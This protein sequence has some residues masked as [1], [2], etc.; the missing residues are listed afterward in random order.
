MLNIL[1]NLSY[2][3]M[4]FNREILGNFDQKSHVILV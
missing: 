2:L 4:N 1:E 3:T